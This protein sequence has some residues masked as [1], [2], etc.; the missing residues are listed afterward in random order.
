MQLKLDNFCLRMS[1]ASAI[2]DTHFFLIKF[3]LHSG[4]RFYEV[5]FY[6][7]PYKLAEGKIFR[8][9]ILRTQLVFKLPI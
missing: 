5:R 4:P 2:I 3:S 9:R 1:S 8:R 6:L 7:K